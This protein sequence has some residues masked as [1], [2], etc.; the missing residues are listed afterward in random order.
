MKHSLRSLMIVPPVLAFA[1]VG[2]HN[3]GAAACG[4][5]VSL[6]FSIIATITWFFASRPRL[7]VRVFC[8]KEDRR[9]G[10]RKCVRDPSFEPSMRMM[11]KLQFAVALWI[12]AVVALGLCLNIFS[13]PLV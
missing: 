2:W 5:L 7:F 11:S 13:T 1:F 8:P 4:I 10:I 9:E 6:M 3:Q 12:G